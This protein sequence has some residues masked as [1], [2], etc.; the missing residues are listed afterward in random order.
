MASKPVFN[1]VPALKVETL[2]LDLLKLDPQN[3]RI[4]RPAHV[5]QIAESIR[6]TGYNAPIL[7]DRDGVVVSG[8]GRVKACKLLG[9]ETVPVIRLEHLTPAQA[10][11]FAI[12][13]NRLVEAGEWDRK[14]LG[15][16]FKVLS[17]LD[18]D[19]AL[20]MTGFSTTE[21]DLLIEDLDLDGSKTDPDDEPLDAGSRPISRLGDIWTLGHHRI[22]CGDALSG[23]TYKALMNGSDADV[24]FTDPPYN[25]RIRGHV[26]A[27][28]RKRHREFAMAS[29]EMSDAEFATFLTQAAQQM[30]AHSRD[31]SVHFLCIDWRH[32]FTLISAGRAAYDDLLNICVWTKNNGG[33][34]SLY[35]SAHEMVVVFRKGRTSH[36]NN[37]EL[38][39]HGRNRTNVWSYPGANSFVRSSDEGDLLAQHPT[40]KPVQMVADALLDVSGR[41]DIV[42]DPFLGSGST[43]IAAERVGRRCY[44]IDLDPSYVDLSIRRW[45]RLTGREAVDGAGQTFA[46]RAHEVEDGQV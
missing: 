9:M 31:G 44:G 20:E 1:P 18:L 42:L 46:E 35:R 23:D 2:A 28:G 17:E 41:G 21:I 33:M 15:N 36:R 19:F 8:N 16:H 32:L 30:A 24:V 12:A 14:I 4:H 11:A 27:K 7:I 26:V 10:R 5:K 3:P 43:L 38:G 13:E 25:V 29:G 40:P 37:V 45:E 22:A 34:G 6:A 39:R